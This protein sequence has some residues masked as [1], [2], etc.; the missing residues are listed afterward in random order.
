MFAQNLFDFILIAFVIFMA[1]QA[2]NIMKK[3]QADKTESA[4]KPLKSEILLEEIRDLLKN[5]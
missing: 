5:K 1:I 4:P 2:I 3:K